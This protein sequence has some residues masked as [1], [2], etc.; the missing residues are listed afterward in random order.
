VQTKKTSSFALKRKN[1]ADRI[2]SVEIR[3]CD[4]RTSISDQL[5]DKGKEPQARSRFDLEAEPASSRGQ[6]LNDD[7]D[8]IGHPAEALA[9]EG[10][11]IM[12]ADPKNQFWW[13]FDDFSLTVRHS[14]CAHGQGNS[15]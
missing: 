14:E 11:K 3:D 6:I 8:F 12:P 15:D 4:G 10:L 2:S 13:I 9:G 1:Q 7:F 5:N